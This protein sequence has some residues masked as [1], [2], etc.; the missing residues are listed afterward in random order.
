MESRRN[1]KKKKQSESRLSTRWCWWVRGGGEY[2]TGK[3]RG[4]RN[5]DGVL[6]GG[7]DEA[8]STP[9]K[10]AVSWRPPKALLQRD[11]TG[12]FRCVS[13][14][15]QHALCSL[16]SLHSDM[17]YPPHRHPLENTNQTAELLFW[18]LF[19]SV[20][21][22][23]SLFFHVIFFLIAFML[24]FFFPWCHSTILFSVSLSSC[25]KLTW[26]DLFMLCHITPIV[27][28]ISYLL[29]DTE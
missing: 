22:S 4:G 21:F 25:S 7:R 16:V 26:T 20:S 11:N 27:Q 28:Q 14:I 13:N 19:D 18:W 17:L 1:R 10:Q 29:L 8:M 15:K 9:Q 23:F 6:P 24:C 2:K 5:R 12:A 3:K